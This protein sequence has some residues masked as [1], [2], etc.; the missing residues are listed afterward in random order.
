MTSETPADGR[1]ENDPLLRAG[2]LG[3]RTE[4]ER[5][6]NRPAPSVA[7]FTRSDTWR[8][9]RIMGEFVE[10]FDALA[11]LGKAVAV[12]GSARIS[13]AD[14]MYER[15]VTLGRCLV[16]DGFAVITGGGPGIME[17]ANKGA[18]EGG[19]L[20]VGC[21]IEL[22]HEQRTNPYVDLSIDFRY[23]FVRKTMFVKYA[24]G[25]VCFPGGFGTMDELFE[26]LNLI[27]TGKVEHF[28][29]VLIGKDYWHGLLQWVER[30]MLAEGKISPG[31]LRLLVV[32]D[33][34]EEA[35]RI[36]SDCYRQRCWEAP[37][38]AA[39]PVAPGQPP[40]SAATARRSSAGPGDSP[41]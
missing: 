32:T 8:V 26:A 27:Q 16:E 19:G 21:N 23:F 15:A 14:P 4:D 29:V 6:L 35:C 2:R 13:A 38:G 28:P 17:A 1:P 30:T 34:V 31:D 33:S 37:R 9:L 22:P 7:D 39:I 36:I 20:S 41:P 18:R 24:E 25:F 40:D 11:G 12:F 5:L 3:Q 10:G